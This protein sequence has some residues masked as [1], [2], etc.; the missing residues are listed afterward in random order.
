MKKTKQDKLAPQTET[1]AKKEYL[2]VS[3]NDITGYKGGRYETESAKVIVH[4]QDKRYYEQ[5]PAK[6]KEVLQQV[7]HD[8]DFE[9][10]EEVIVY[11]GLNA[12]RESLDAARCLNHNTGKVKIVAC[13]CQ[14][15]EKRQAVGTV[16]IIESE[17]G[18]RK[19]LGK[20]IE[21]I[22]QGTYK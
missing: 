11:S 12:M 4:C 14:M 17:C 15:S 19:T 3:Y 5:S 13:D 16:P 10:L 1:Q 22:L 2:V 21:N 7:Y 18:G 8:V 6:L 20:I 9:G